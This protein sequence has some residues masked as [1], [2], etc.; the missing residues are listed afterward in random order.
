MRTRARSLFSAVDRPSDGLASFVVQDQVGTRS[1]TI[2]PALDA[3]LRFGDGCAYGMLGSSAIGIGRCRRNMRLTFQTIA[4]FVV[5]TA[6][7]LAQDVAAIGF[8]AAEVAR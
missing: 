1:G 7:M 6:D 8:V 2:E 5:R 3:V 4:K